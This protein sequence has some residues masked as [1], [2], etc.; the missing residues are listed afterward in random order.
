MKIALGKVIC[1]GRKYCG[2]KQDYMAYKLGITVHAYANIERGRV[3]ISAS[4]LISVAKLFGLR[5]H[6]IFELAEE[7][8]I[9]EDDR[10]I[11][12]HV[13]GIIRLFIINPEK[14]KLTLEG[15]F[16]YELDKTA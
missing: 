1:A 6:Q 2:F 7:V 9:L 15:E 5:G 11:P 13:K 10:C 4:K 14:Y 8:F 3:D 16:E 12:N